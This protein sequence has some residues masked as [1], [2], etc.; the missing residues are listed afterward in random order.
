[1]TGIPQQN[2]AI[3]F[4]SFTTPSYILAQQPNCQYAATDLIISGSP[5]AFVS[6]D[7]IDRNFDLTTENDQNL[8]NL[9]TISVQSSITFF[10]D[11]TKTTS[12]TLQV[13]VDTLIN[14]LSCAVSS[15]TSPTNVGFTS[16]ALG[17]PG[18][19]FGNWVF[20]QS[21]G[22]SYPET[23]TLSGE[24]VGLLELDIPNKQFNII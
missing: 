19:Q 8:A 11:F 23:Y 13:Q 14:L 3:G 24:P 5:P 16:Y 18:F 20:V 22:C 7:S 4:T 9:Y 10:D 2:I 21:N 17:E 1:M 12:T 6:F 15:F